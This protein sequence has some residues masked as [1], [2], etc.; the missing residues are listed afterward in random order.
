[1]TARISSLALL[2]TLGLFAGASS[3]ALSGG[4]DQPFDVAQKTDK[5][6]DKDSANG[7]HKKKD[8]DA[9]NKDNAQE[10][11]KDKGNWKQGNQG[12][13]DATNKKFE[14]Q[15]QNGTEPKGQDAFKQKQLEIKQA[16]EK[17]LKE[18]QQADAARQEA[19]KK[20]QLEIKQAREK[21]LNEKKQADEAKS[22]KQGDQG[23][24]KLGKDDKDKFRWAKP[25]ETDKSGGK[26]A[27]KNWQGKFDKAK[28]DSEFDKARARAKDA[29]K[30]GKSGD[31]EKWDDARAKKFEDFRKQRQEKKVAGGTRDIFTEPDKRVIVR[32]KNRAYIR[33]DETLRFNKTGRELRRERQKDGTIL[34]V[35]M[36][37]AGALIY[38]FE[39]DHGRLMRRSR[40]GRDGR[41]FILID[42][43]RYYGSRPWPGYDDGS[44][45]SSY[46]DLPPPVIR[47]PRN[48]YIVEYEEASAE[49]IYE[50]LSAPPVEDLGRGYSLDEVRQSYELLER[51]R[52]VDLS[53]ITFDFGSWDIG[54]DQYQKLSRIGDAMRRILDRSP[55]EMFLIEGHTD[56]VGSDIDNLSLS[57]RR[58]ESVAVVLSEEFGVPPE[59]LVTQGYGE[60]YL[61]VPT[62]EP[63]RINRRV[64]VRRITPL[65]DR[66]Y[67]A[68]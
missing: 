43:R 54:P 30:D 38:S 39:D 15:K 48:K 36:G 3:P 7:Q 13:S 33:H 16:R 28:S 61:K 57:D 29:Q 53:S 17:A 4:R 22:K 50:A 31:R 40:K 45:Y 41:E 37:L 12:K 32:D 25:V 58:A 64:G 59:N 51:M 1:M 34:I 6:D 56:A 46:V 21:A 63:S 42:N 66:Q 62:E 24:D 68:R 8:K 20:K 11:Q 27:S 60:Q 9:P 49:D 35:T 14:G 65:L 44:Y 19:I 23:K 55:D 5:D 52:R 67:S 2:A 26:D 10:K 18:K 47:I